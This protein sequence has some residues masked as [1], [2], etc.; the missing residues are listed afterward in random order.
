MDAPRGKR[1]AHLLNLSIPPVALVTA[2]LILWDQAVGWRDLAILAAMYLLAGLGVTLGFHRLFTHRCYVTYRPIG[3]VL[4]ILGQMALQGSVLDWVADHRKHHA[5]ADRDGDP[6][7][8]HGEGSTVRN[9]WYAHVGWLF[10]HQGSAEKERYAPDLIRDPAIRAIDRG[11]AASVALSLAL[12]FALGLGLGGSVAAGLTA[13]LWGGVVRIFIFQHA[14]FSLNSIAHFYGRRS[15]P[16][17][18]RSTDVFWL[19]PATLGEGWHNTHHAFP[20]AASLRRHWWQLDP[21]G[22]AISALER[23][24]LA[25]DVHRITPELEREMAGTG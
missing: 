2:I 13:L 8:P 3:W 1:L 17:N 14:I 16:T 15:F 10:R 7:S 12:P 21:S 6:H 23:L 18:D 19:V 5:H 20:R 9:L 25:W 24:G 4:A 22:A 11:F